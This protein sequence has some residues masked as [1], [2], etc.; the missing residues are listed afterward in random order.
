[1]TA[2]DLAVIDRLTNGK[3]GTINVACPV[4]GPERRSP[5]NQRRRVLR[6][7]RIDPNFATF[8]CARCGEHGYFRR[9]DR[10][11]NIDPVAVARARAEAA[12]RER[13]SSADRLS[14]ARWLWSRRKPIIGS[15]AETYLRDVR[16]YDG[17]LPATLGFLPPRGKHGPAMIAAFGIAREINFGELRILDDDVVGVHITRLLTIGTKARTDSDKIMIGSSLGYPIIL[18]PPNDLLGLAITEGIEDAL[19]VHDATGLGAWAAGSASRLPALAKTVPR[20]IESITIIGDD[21][22]DGRHHAVELER[23]LHQEG[24]D[25]RL[26]FPE[27]R[28][29]AA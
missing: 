16:R 27:Y 9:D 2:L 21:D 17:P 8:N 24:C 18:A 5:V 25:V 6:I 7:W 11:V 29:A 28:S 1:M 15:V 26:I 22:K 20:Y 12:E 4:C 3:I 13:K 23:L 10:A 19:S 14:K